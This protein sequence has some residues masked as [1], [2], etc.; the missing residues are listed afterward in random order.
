MADIYATYSGGAVDPHAI[1]AYI[2]DVN[3]SV[4]TATDLRIRIFKALGE[5]GIEIPFPQQDV[6]LRD[7]DFVKATVA[8]MAAERSMRAGAAPREAAGEDGERGA[9]KSDDA[10]KGGGTPPR[11]L[12]TV[13]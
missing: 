13:S 12:R 8:R 10:N 4:S 9:A 7:L 1:R 6:H 3:K 5:A 11:N 2:A